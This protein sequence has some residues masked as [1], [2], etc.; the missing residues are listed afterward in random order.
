MTPILVSLALAA[1]FSAEP[2]K[3]HQP[4]PFAPSLPLLTDEE[5]EQLDG[6]IDRFIE[7]DICK[8]TGEAARKAQRDFD[9]LGM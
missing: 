3:P 5:E 8:L 1:L 7:A 2:D 9:K 4:N 6:I